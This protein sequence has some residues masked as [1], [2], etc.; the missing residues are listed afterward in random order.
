MTDVCSVYRKELSSNRDYRK[1]K[2]SKSSSFGAP[3]WKSI[4]KLPNDL[5]QKW[6]GKD[7]E[8]ESSKELCVDAC[9]ERTNLIEFN[10]DMMIMV[11][12]YLS[13]QE[14]VRFSSVS[15]RLHQSL[16]SD[17]LWEQLWIQRYTEL[18]Q[19]PTMQG[20]LG[21]RG[22]EWDPLRNWGPPSQGWKLFLLE[23]EYG[24]CRIIC[25]TTREE[26]RRDEM[27]WCVF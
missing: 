14:I 1:I 2:A 26:M 23:F 4:S 22:I 10:V 13:N 25:C 12:S 6:P 20:I 7:K 15:S 24:Q 21:H 11:A 3:D 5:M 17:L 9:Y 27:I 19:H 8:T 16:A 18:W